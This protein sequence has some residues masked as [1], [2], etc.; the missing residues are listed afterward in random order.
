[1]AQRF[2]DTA[3]SVGLTQVSVPHGLFYSSGPTIAVAP[4]EWAV[5][6]RGPLPAVGLAG[7]GA[8]F[9]SVYISAEP[10]TTNMYIAAGQ[11]GCLADVS[12]AYNQSEIR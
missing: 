3:V 10:D 5:T 11:A 7:A 12:C 6:Q 2:M 8:G 4:H 9:A 1:M